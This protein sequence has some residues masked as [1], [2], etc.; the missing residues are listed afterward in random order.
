MLLRSTF[1]I[2]LRDIGAFNCEL[3]DDHL[4]THFTGS[5][6]PYTQSMRER[7]KRLLALTYQFDAYFALSHEMPPILHRQEVGVDLQSSFALWNAHGLDIFAMRELEESPGRSG[8]QICD[9]ATRPDSLK[10]SKLLVEDIQLGLCGLLQAIWVIKRPLSSAA[11]VD[12]VSNVSQ[13]TM[14]IET[15]D[16]WKHELDQINELASERNI[17]SN[18]ARYLFQAYRGEDDSVAASSELATTLVQDAMILYYYLKMYHYTGVNASKISGLR[19]K[20]VEDPWIETWQNSKD[21]REAL[22]CALEMLKV[23]DSIGASNASLNPLIRHALAIGFNVTRVM[24]SFQKCE[25]LAIEGQHP[26]NMDFRS[27]TEIGGPLWIDGILVCVCKLSF[28]TESFE[29]A[30]QGQKFMME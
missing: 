5:Y 29:K 20:Q 23:V 6:A 8:S 26:A 14:L 3:F 10:S 1:V 16:A 17:T 30:I 25:C 7:F 15:L 27:W 22:V 9:I 19:V 24:V 4:K 18:T 12:D 21:G 2:I 13:R 28:W 11:W